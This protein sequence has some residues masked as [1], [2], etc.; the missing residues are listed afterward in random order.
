[1]QSRRV[2][3]G[4]LGLALV[5]LTGS[6]LTAQQRLFAIVVNQPRGNSTTSLVEAR[7]ESGQISDVRPLT[8]LNGSGSTPVVTGGGQFVTW[9]HSQ[10]SLHSLAVYD[11][12]AGTAQ[13]LPYPSV[14]AISDPTEVRLFVPADSGLTRLTPAGAF[15]FPNTAGLHYPSVS[16]DGRR[17]LA[18]AAISAG[19]PALWELRAFDTASGSPLGAMAVGVAPTQTK[20]AA[21]ER[22][23]WV[24]SFPPVGNGHTIVLR[25]L[26]VP[27]AT[28][29]LAT[30]I[31]VSPYYGAI[32]ASL[33]GLDDTHGRIFVALT[34]FNLGVSNHG[35]LITLDTD[36]GAEVARVDLEGVST[37]FLDVGSGRVL[38]LSASLASRPVSSCRNT[39]LRTVAVDTGLEVTRSLV[40]TD[41]CLAVAFAAPPPAPVLAAPVVTPARSVVLNWARSAELIA[42][43]TVEAGTGP[44]LAD[45][46]VLPVTGTTLTVPNVPVGSYYVRVKA[47]NDIGSSVPSNEIAVTVP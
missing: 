3:R 9:A 7:I 20:L 13:L 45:I 10:G 40:D 30:T 35:Q 38:T 17:L 6:S 28:Q 34:D 19:P 42:Q 39:T 46:A 33:V 29:L 41:A 23:V 31:A 24:L 37:S 32:N 8:V 14:G 47:W 27:S 12:R 22:S 43:F 36:S 1:M 21:D 2:A 44:G 5:A 11:R 16:P 25:Q 15:V 18:L 4:V 26:D